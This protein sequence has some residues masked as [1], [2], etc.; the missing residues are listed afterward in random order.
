MKNSKIKK[1]KQKKSTLNFKV[2]IMTV[3]L[4]IKTL[5]ISKIKSKN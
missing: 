5:K 2:N 3:N 1:R 4:Q